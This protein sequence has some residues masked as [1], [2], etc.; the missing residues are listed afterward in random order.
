MVPKGQGRD[1]KRNE[2]LFL[3]EIQ[4]KAFIVTL[5]E[6]LN[7]LSKN[8]CGL[9]GVILEPSFQCFSSQIVELVCLVRS[10]ALPGVEDVY[11]VG[12]SVISSRRVRGLPYCRK[13]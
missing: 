10:A 7:W 6:G 4:S 12:I 11:V 3:A 8:E 5:G 9:Y 1:R 2:K 13:Y